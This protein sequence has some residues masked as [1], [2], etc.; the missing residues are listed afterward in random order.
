[1]ERTI[2]GIIMVAGVGL[3]LS[4]SVLELWRGN[5]SARGLIVYAVAMAAYGALVLAGIAPGATGFGAAA[6][7]VIAGM[8][9]IGV[10]LSFRDRRKARQAR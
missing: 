5:R 6:M 10:Y 2:L 8:A 9:W 1:M 3:V 7:W 4:A